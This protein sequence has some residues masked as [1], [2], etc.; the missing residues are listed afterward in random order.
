MDLFTGIGGMTLALTG[1]SRPVLY[2]DK[3]PH[4]RRVLLD[5]MARSQLPKAPVLTDVCHVQAQLVDCITAGFP[6][7]GFT[8]VGDMAGFNHPESA[9]FFKLVDV[10][11][12]SKPAMVFMEN[13]PAIAQTESL[14]VMTK[15]FKRIGYSLR[16][17]VLPVYAVGLPQ[18]RNRWF[19]LAWRDEDALARLGKRV[20]LGRAGITI[21]P[22]EP[23]RT[24]VTECRQAFLRY[25]LL[26]NA[27]VPEVAYLALSLLTSTDQVMTVP[28]YPKPDLKLVL[29]Q[30]GVVHHKKLWPTL[31]GNYCKTPAK[32]LT[33]RA[34]N[35]IISA[36]F[37]ERRTK[38]GYPNIA[39]LEWLMGFPK[40]WTHTHVEK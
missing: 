30:G 27:V 34:T 18:A 8:S 9:L 33:D 39:F 36:I 28:N 1:I 31:F 4:A 23:A 7:T 26:K 24:V 40:D 11:K 17:C 19:G 25:Q 12:A 5:R 15:A 29:R 13:T 21:R 37:F 6:C 3:C 14:T 10:C 20:K 16:S 2:C 38:P 22:K 32:N 35:N